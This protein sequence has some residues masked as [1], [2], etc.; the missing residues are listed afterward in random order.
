MIRGM[1]IGQ[2]EVIVHLEEV[3]PRVDSLVRQAVRAETLNLVR[4]AKEKVSGPVLKTKTGTLRRGI[5]A[6]F[7]ETDT[8]IIGSA[9]IGKAE[10]KYPA[11]HEFGGTVTVREH[12]RR[13]TMAWGRAV[14]TPR[15]ISVRAHTAT[16]PERSF[17]RSTLR[18]NEARIKAAIAAAVTQGV[19]G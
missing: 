6:E 2:E 13:M 9:G 19:K 14:K 10:A 8:S 3:H 11:V 16:Y 5:N 17:L 18:E 7:E 1:V 15:Q 4:E 12:T